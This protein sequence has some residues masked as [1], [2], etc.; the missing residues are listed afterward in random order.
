MTPRQSPSLPSGMQSAVRPAVVLAPALMLAAAVGALASYDWV[1]GPWHPLWSLAR[2]FVEH[3]SW[4]WMLTGLLVLSTVVFLILGTGLIFRYRYYIVATITTALAAVSGI[5]IGRL[6][7][8][9]VAFPIVLTFWLATTFVENKPIL[10][11]KFVLAVLLVIA[12]F[13]IGSIVNGRAT[14]IFSLHSILGKLVF[15]FLISNIIAERY[16]HVF[17]LKTIVFVGVTSAAVAVLSQVLF[18]ASGL[19]FVFGDYLNQRYK[20]TPIGTMLRATGFASTPQTLGNFLVIALGLALL[21][22]ISIWI[23][24][25]MAF[26]LLAGLVV[27]FSIGAVGVGLI[28][29]CLAPFFRYPQHWLPIL[30]FYVLSALLLYLSGVVEWFMAGVLEKMLYEGTSARTELARNGIAAMGRHPL[31][32]AG[33]MNISRV[34]PLPIH[35]T[36]LQ[37]AYEIGL[38]S[39]LAFAG[40]LAYLGVRLTSTIV[41]LQDSTT[42]FWL[43]GML[44]SLVGMVVHYLTEPMFVNLMPWVFLGLISGAIVAYERR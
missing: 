41:R 17:T 35:N 5:N 28:V 12:A 24:I 40:L 43:K 42:R 36:Y 39:A 38:P 7:T 11:P 34:L 8:F 1:L 30:L 9:E 26:L 15:L 4:L 29:I 32:G 19:E 44:L 33:I 31:L 23:C 10:T 18:F 22:P 14:S 21:A 2:D 37:A 6:D 3:P 13:T 25:G 20:S 27:T 16:I